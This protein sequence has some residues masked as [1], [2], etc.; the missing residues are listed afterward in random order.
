MNRKDLNSPTPPGR[1]ANGHHLTRL[2]LNGS[3]AIIRH[4]IR[5]YQSAG[6]IEVVRRKQNVESALQN[7]KECQA[8]ADHH[9]GWRYFFEKTDLAA[10]TNPVEATHLRQANFEL[11]ESKAFQETTPLRPLP[12]RR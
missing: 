1:A 3:Y 12:P 11:R 5:T 6:V 7:L 9:E 8:S 4:N 2:E 10:G